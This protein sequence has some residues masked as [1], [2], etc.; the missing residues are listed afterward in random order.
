MTKQ[1]HSRTLG[2][3]PRL[4]GLGMTFLA[5]F[6]VTVMAPVASA[7]EGDAQG[8][9]ELEPRTL[10]Q[11]RR[12]IPLTDVAG[13]IRRAEVR[14]LSFKDRGKTVGGYEVGGKELERE[15]AIYREMYSKYESGE[16]QVTEFELRGT[17][18]SAALGSLAEEVE[19]RFELPRDIL[20]KRPARSPAPDSSTPMNSPEERDPDGDTDGNDDGSLGE[21]VEP[22]PDVVPELPAAPS[23]PEPEALPSSSVPEPAA[24]TSSSDALTLSEAEAE[25][26]SAGDVIAA[27]KKGDNKDFAPW[28][29]SVDAYETSNP[30]PRHF[31]LNLQWENQSDIDDFGDLEAYEHDFKLANDRAPTFCGTFGDYHWAYRYGDERRGSV[32]WRTTFP[33]GTNPYIDT[34]LSDECTRMDFTVGLFDP[35]GLAPEVSYNIYI[36][37][38]AGSVSSENFKLTAQAA[39]NDCAGLNAR[40]CVAPFSD[41]RMD[42]LVSV[43][44]PGAFVPGCFDWYQDTPELNGRTTRC[45]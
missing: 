29:G 12:P 22:P 10:F 25:G 4:L 17:V 15:L 26:G 3:R 19:R 5:L 6:A 11:L 7:A 33:D 44:E 16:P 27:G 14:P 8:L 13:S 41:K 24:P 1:V 30:L 2:E 34:Q 42:D 39:P 9:Q 23:V 18:P 37:A 20:S 45:L 43:R 31:T 32:A 21:E 35:Q 36:D 28:K 38:E 40:L